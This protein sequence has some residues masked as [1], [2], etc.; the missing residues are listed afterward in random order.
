MA[1]GDGARPGSD[2]TK[3]LAVGVLLLATGWLLWTFGRGALAIVAFG[4]DWGQMEI[5]AAVG[6]LSP[7]GLAWRD[8]QRDVVLSVLGVINQTSTEY[9][10]P[11]SLE[12]EKHFVRSSE[13]VAQ[14]TRWPIAALMLGLSVMMLFRMRGERFRRQF[15]LTG[16]SL[17]TVYRT[18]HWRG[19]SSFWKRC[20]ERGRYSPLRALLWLLMLCHVVRAAKEWTRDAPDFATYQAQHW[21]VA[22]VGSAFDPD[23]DEPAWRQQMT[24]PE[25]LR[26]NKVSL[27][28]QSGLD[29]EA[30]G[31]AFAQQLGSTWNGVR[32]A[33]YQAQAI[34]IMAALNRNWETAKLGQLAN[35]LAFIHVQN[36]PSGAAMATARE[37]LK[38]FLQNE[39]LVRA[40]DRVAAQHHYMST[41]VLRVYGW[42]GPFEEWGG[43]EGASFAPSQFLWLKP[44]DR[45]LWYAL[46]Q[47][48]RRAFMIEGAGTVSHY[49]FERIGRRPSST[50]KVEAAIEGLEKYLSYHHIGDL[51]AFFLEQKQ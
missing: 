17:S 30:A 26:E 48:G 1:K 46:Q 50:P 34:C 6:S 2:E 12:W 13:I 33:P 20:A 40:I 24:P 16:R 39:G 11:Y 42:G 18:L 32:H 49:F 35:K 44:V 43:G 22:L 47:N 27:T 9:V 19:L 25:W 15:S 8:M 5:A 10:D 36:Q 14:W 41:A 28:T 4:L 3:Y 29:Q 21:Q 7:N 38:P 37:L 45:N 51:N 31:R 23:K